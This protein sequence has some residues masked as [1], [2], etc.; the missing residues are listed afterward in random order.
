[1]V[2]EWGKQLGELLFLWFL[3]VFGYISV[4]VEEGVCVRD[5]RHFGLCKV[6]IVVCSVG[7]KCEGVKD[8]LVTG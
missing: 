2:G 4:V 8:S 1:V 7:N 5:W 6:S 3:C